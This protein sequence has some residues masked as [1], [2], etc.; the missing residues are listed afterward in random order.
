MRHV[1]LF[2]AAVAVAS[3]A[4][5]GDHNH[6]NGPTAAQVID[7]LNHEVATLQD[8]IG[9]GQAGNQGPATDRVLNNLNRLLDSR[10]AA[11]AYVHERCGC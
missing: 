6:H 9:N 5:A 3:P 7:H 2:L 1:I 4:F 11:L 10:E 8:A